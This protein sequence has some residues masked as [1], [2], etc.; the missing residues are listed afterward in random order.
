VNTAATSTQTSPV[1]SIQL[2]GTNTGSSPPQALRIN[3]SGGTTGYLATSA[4]GTLLA[5]AAADA[6]NSTDLG[7]TT[8]ADVDNR[9]I[10]TLNSSGDEVY[11]ASYTGNGG[12]P[13]TGNQCRAATSLDNTTWF[14][15]DKGGIY[16]TS[17]SSP[18]TTPDSTTNMLVTKSFGGAVYGFSA[19]APGV[20]SVVSSGE[21]IGTLASLTGLSIASYTDFYL[22]SS[23]VNGAAFDICYVSVGTSTTAGTINKYSLVSGSWVANGTYTT[24][25]GGRSMV[26]AG[27]GTGATLYLTGGDGG[28]SGTSVVKVTDTAGYNQTINVVTANNLNLYTFASGSTGPVAKGIAFAPLA[29]ALPD[30]TIAASAP[31]FVSSGANFNYTLTVANSGSAGASGVTAQLTLPS[32]LTYVSSADTGSAGFTGSNNSGVVTFTSGT[33]AANTSETLTVTVS[34]SDSTYI[35]DAGTSPATGHGFA[36]INTSAT[37]STPIAE[38]N[39]ANNSSNVGATTHVGTTP[40]LTVSASG[41]STAVANS[42][43][44][45]VTYTIIAQNIGNATATSVNV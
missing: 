7:Q 36:V 10:V 29:T 31:S 4:D 8:A 5:V 18:A 20:S 16:T 34:G 12:V 32:G 2:P 14:V 30:L 45:P 3:G 23:G 39:A 44:S 37:T 41:S 11:Q 19:T 43:G 24:S 1:Q 6:T 17:S 13:A 42:T 33:L 25:F 26:A 22:I 38:S 9:E 28:H 35:V 27:N 21:S 15:A 40:Y